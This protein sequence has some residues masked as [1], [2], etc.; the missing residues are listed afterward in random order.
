MIE[1]ICYVLGHSTFM[2]LAVPG[3][4]E[5]LP[6]KSRALARY[7]SSEGKIGRN[8]TDNGPIAQYDER[9][10]AASIGK[11]TNHDYPE[12]SSQLRH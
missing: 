7:L 6:K 11:T 3:G 4:V 9:Y 2:S 10:L 8:P 5:Y 12:N 1:F